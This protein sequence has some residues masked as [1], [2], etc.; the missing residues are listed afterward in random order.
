MTMKGAFV[1]AAVAG[2]F[3]SAVPAVAKAGSGDKVK[4]MGIN[5][6]KGKA[7]CKSATSSC[8]GQNDCKGKGWIESSDKE[9]KAKKGTVVK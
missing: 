9:C 8:K 6:C 2:L 7:A 5:D 3:A 4:C 1:A